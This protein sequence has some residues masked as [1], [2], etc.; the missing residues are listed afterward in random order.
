MLTNTHRWSHVPGNT[1]VPS[2]WQATELRIVSRDTEEPHP[3]IPGCGPWSE[4]SEVTKM[5]CVQHTHFSL[6]IGSYMG[7][8]GPDCLC[9]LEFPVFSRAGM[10][11]ESHLGHK[12][13]P[14]QRGFCSNARTLTLLGVPL[15]LFPWLVPG[16]GGGLFRCVGSGLGSWLV[17]P[18]PAVQLLRGSSFRFC[19]VGRG[20]PTSI[21]GSELRGTT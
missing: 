8:I 14:C 7:W 10:R 17:G 1:V 21:H 19:R 9:F 20:W 6:R 4:S 18:P 12:T 13:S 2:R 15:T 3:F 11:F 16:R 5:V